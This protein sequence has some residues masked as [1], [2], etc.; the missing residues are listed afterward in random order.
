MAQ[1]DRAQLYNAL[2]E[3]G[4]PFQKHYKH[5]TTAELE[6]LYQGNLVKPAAAPQKQDPNELPSQRRGREND[7]IRTDEH[8]YEWYQEEIVKSNQA[9]PRGYRIYRE[10]TTDTKEVTIETTESNGLAYTETFEVPGEK[11]RPMEVKVGTPTWQVGIYRDPY[12]KFARIVKCKDA[13]GFL[14][15]DVDN[16]FGGQDV[17]PENIK[18]TTVGN[19]ICYEINTVVAA[20]QREYNARQLRGAIL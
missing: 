4:Y 17:L 3:A 15:E 6:D 7:I 1:A 16:F 9:K 18:R 14:R 20:I 2:K 8:G 13:R 19:I 5:Y 11:Q 10:M 12:M